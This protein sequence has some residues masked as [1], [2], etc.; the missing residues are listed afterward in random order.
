MS[1]KIYEKWIDL[2][3]SKNFKSNLMAAGFSKC[4][5]SVDFFD[6]NNG[7]T[8]TSGVGGTYEVK[9]QDTMNEQSL[10][11]V[12][13]SPVTASDKDYDRPFCSGPVLFIH[14]DFNS[15]TGGKFARVNVWRAE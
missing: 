11:T 2:T 14:I 7:E 4:V 1:G 12:N 15:V 6:D 9:A 5:V 8:V 13:S 3:Q 10:A